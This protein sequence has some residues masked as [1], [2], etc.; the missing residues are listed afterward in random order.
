MQEHY[1]AFISYRH[2]ELDS[3]IAEHVQRSLEH[4]SIPGKIKKK[5]NFNK[6]ER[7]FRDKDELPITA[8]LNDTIQNAL[9]NADYLIVICSPSTRESVWVLREIEFFLSTHSRDKV[10]TVLADGEP[11]EVIPEIL[12]KEERT[13]TDDSGNEVKITVDLEPLS[14]DYRMGIRKADKEE[15]PR[16]ASCLIGCTY[17]EL[18]NRRRQYRARRAAII[19]AA[20]FVALIAFGSY[21]FFSMKQV[22]QSLRQ[23]Q[24]SNSQYLAGESRRLLDNHERIKAI[25][26]ALLALPG[27]DRDIP[28]IPEAQRVL[29]DAVYAY[30]TENTSDIGA[31]WNYSMSTDIKLINISDDGNILVAADAANNV[32][33]WNT[34]TKDNLFNV[35]NCP[36]PILGV[37]F[38]P[39]SDILT[40]YTEENLYAYNTSNGNKMWEFDSPVDFNGVPH[41]SSDGKYIYLA[42]FYYDFMVIQV[43]SGELVRT[44][45]SNYSQDYVIC[46]EMYTSPDCS[47]FI[48][49]IEDNT[50]ES[51]EYAIILYDMNTNSE[52]VID[53]VTACD[54]YVEWVDNS[55]VIIQTITTLDGVFFGDEPTYDPTT[56]TTRCVDISTNQTMWTNEISYWDNGCRKYGI[57]AKD[58][59]SYIAYAGS[60]IESYNVG[61][62][63]INSQFE[64]SSSVLKA[65]VDIMTGLPYFYTYNG[66]T[67]L[68]PSIIEYG[69][70]GETELTDKNIV[71]VVANN[72]IYLVEANSNSIIELNYAL[73]DDNWNTSNGELFPNYKLD[74]N[75][76]YIDND[77]CILIDSYNDDLYYL[78]MDDNSLSQPYDLDSIVSG[79]AYNPTFLGA[80]NNNVYLEY[81]S[82]EGKS[83]I[84]ID[85]DTRD[86][87]ILR[88]IDND[89]VKCNHSLAGKYILT[90]SGYDEESRLVLINLENNDITSYSIE[91]YSDSHEMVATILPNANIIHYVDSL[92]EDHFI[93]INKKREI[94][95]DLP[96]DWGN[97][98]T[99][100]DSSSDRI[101]IAD[102]T[103]IAVFDYEGNL[104]TEIQNNLGQVEKLYIYKEANSSNENLF[105]IIDT[106]FL[107]R[108]DG[109]Y[110]LLGSTRITLTQDAN[111][112]ITINND[113]KSSCLYIM[114]N[115]ILDII[116]TS[117][118][119]EVASVN[120]AIG[121]Y[122][123]SDRIYTYSRIEADGLSIGYFDHYS[124]EEL[125]QMGRDII[126]DYTMS[127]EERA[128]YGL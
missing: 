99:I 5:Y 119:Y 50:M 65:T 62:G 100:T 108:Y 46:H 52:T 23:S 124:V 110:Q 75:N 92:G 40:V 120:N 60:R 104:I 30:V 27:E 51:N 122:N 103:R 111:K 49:F 16:L 44:Y 76:I 28:L 13:V 116:E 41:Y 26:L 107:C 36:N 125:E 64:V 33:V 78:D 24:M 87:G 35:A 98:L 7:V 37:D 19:I 81:D 68:I 56:L 69:Y 53:Q 17:D 80:Y 74:S 128:E 97:T 21:I 63:E 45:E 94:G 42:D 57:F 61:T 10:L 85:T 6:I 96:D 102:N 47:K 115:N 3:K 86:I 126:G 109:E 90:T 89:Y 32:S 54:Y 14:C 83:I 66:T 8:N 2:A 22:Q 29:T 84:E 127:D 73:F 71:D 67:G 95:F 55:K 59:D 114:D 11:F 79:Y 1:N 48:S 20:V 88:N 105:V 112:I 18:M 77:V 4:F 91:N 25:Q 9:L 93:D 34:Q 123:Q 121:H 106:G 58:T 113:P 82:F 101:Y 72:G 31:V 70:Y 39:N 15:L 118:W 43:S 38:V 12:L 117:N